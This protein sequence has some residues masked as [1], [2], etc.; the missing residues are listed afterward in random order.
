[1]RLRRK[2]ASEA[3]QATLEFL[4]IVP[5]M[6]A[7]ISLVGLAGW[8]SY[9]KLSAQNAAYGW[10]VWN[11]FNKPSASGPKISFGISGNTDAM[12]ATLQSPLGMKEIW[13]DTTASIEPHGD[14]YFWR[15]G[16]TS[17][18]IWVA[19]GDVSF[20]QVLDIWAGR[21]EDRMPRGTAYFFYGPFNSARK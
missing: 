6:L 4:I 18:I 10:G 19:P 7:L 12:P 15:K 21:S 14:Y 3:G 17:V 16:G 2:R 9:A 8:W 1:M 5:L 13:G 11:S 20:A